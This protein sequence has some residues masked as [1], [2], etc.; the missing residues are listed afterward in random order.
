MIEWI[1]KNL[2]WLLLA[3]AVLVSPFINKDEYDRG[4]EKGFEDALSVSN[5]SYKSNSSYGYDRQ[6]TWGELFDHYG[7]VYDT[8]TSSQQALVN[9][10]RL[11]QGCVYYVQGGKSYHS[12]NWCYTLSN[13]KN[14]QHSSLP[15]ARAYQLD[16]CSKCVDSKQIQ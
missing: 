15:F 7:V 11:D 16:P 6:S 2:G 1:K 8:L 10:P 14:I 13:S 9:Y 4:Y 3:I 5:Y 12:V